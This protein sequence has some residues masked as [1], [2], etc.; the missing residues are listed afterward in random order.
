MSISR[1]YALNSENSQFLRILGI[2]KHIHDKNKNIGLSCHRILKKSTRKTPLKSIP[3]Q[4]SVKIED[5]P[6]IS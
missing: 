2:I 6:L 1:N 4:I 3:K 5:S